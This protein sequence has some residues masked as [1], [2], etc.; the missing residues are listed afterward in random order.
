MANYTILS[1]EGM[2]R[3]DF[4]W[5]F[6]HAEKGGKYNVEWDDKVE[7]YVA[8]ED[9]PAG[10]ELLLKFDEELHLSLELSVA[11]IEELRN[12][13]EG[14]QNAEEISTTIELMVDDEETLVPF[15]TSSLAR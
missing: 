11:F 15:L 8:T 9:V 3:M 12:D 7:A 14:L 6:N 2:T 13:I 10:E 5:F 4:G 1:R